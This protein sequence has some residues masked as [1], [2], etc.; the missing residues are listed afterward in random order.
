MNPILIP[1]TALMIPMVIVP[2][3]LWLRHRLRVREMEHSERVRA[4]ELGL[5][6]RKTDL[7][8]PGAAICIGIGAGVPIGSMLIAWLAMMTNDLPSEVFG[9]PLLISLSAI[10]AAKGLA[11]RML[12]RRGDDELVDATQRARTGPDPKAK[13]DPDA[14]DVV[15]S[16]G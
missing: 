9:I 5:A 1:I 13:F 10:W 14:Y 4:M 16:R 6:P 12:S 7:S 2:T 11:D 3:S 15:G 8:W